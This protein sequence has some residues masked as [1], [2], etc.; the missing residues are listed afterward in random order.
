MGAGRGESCLALLEGGEKILSREGRG[1]KMAPREI[2]EETK[3]KANPVQGRKCSRRDF[4]TG[5]PTIL[6]R[7]G[8]ILTNLSSF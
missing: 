7:G 6:S 4:R 8:L 2:E 5:R 1:R 3:Q